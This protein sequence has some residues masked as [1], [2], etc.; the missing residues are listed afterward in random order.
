MKSMLSETDANRLIHLCQAFASARRDAWTS[1]VRPSD[2][3]ALCK[4]EDD[5]QRAFIDAVL[6]LTQ[7]Q[8][9]S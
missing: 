5:A 1:H 4:A 9:L 7:S 6:H 3:T 2:Y 8:T